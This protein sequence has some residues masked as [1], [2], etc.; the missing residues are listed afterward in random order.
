MYS[1]DYI[2]KTLNYYFIK[3]MS[4]NKISKELNISRQIV[5][6]W[7]NKFNNDI[8]FISNRNKIQNTKLNTK[9][10]NID[11]HIFIKELIYKNPFITRSQIIENIYLKFQIKLTKNNISNIYKQLNMTRKKVKYHI[12]KNKEFIDNLIIKRKQ[13]NDEIKNKNI[14]KI[15]SIDESG[16]NKNLSTNYGLSEKGV[17]IN[18]PIK[19]KLN[20]NISLIL[21]I[22]TNNILNIQINKE[23]TNSSIF[24]NFIED[25]INKLT[26]TGY[27]FIFDNICFHHN[28]QTLKLIKDTGHNYM[29]TPAYSP[30]NN[31][32]ENVFSIIKNKYNKSTEK[33]IID[34]INEIKIEYINFNSLFMRSLNFNYTNIEKELR[35]RI[36]FI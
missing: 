5:S 20:K 1:N 18:M 9:I 28:K 17:K 34:I 32:V 29:F 26:E 23:N 21:A 11:I 2:Y 36:N 35:D 25:T 22:T 27:I 19:P 10:S 33:Q 13:F 16:F 7:I 30:N 4:F 8:N 6:I 24:Y 3:K 12:I 31:P 15:I 14:H